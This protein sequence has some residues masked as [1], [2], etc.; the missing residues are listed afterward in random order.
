[1]C[2]G[3]CAKHMCMHVH[4][5]VNI[6]Y[7]VNHSSSYFMRLNVSLNLELTDWIFRLAKKNPIDICVFNPLQS[8]YHI[9]RA[10]KILENGSWRSSFFMGSRCWCI[11]TYKYAVNNNWKKSMNLKKRGE[12][13]IAWFGGRNEKEENVV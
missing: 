8:S 1:M 9:T 13:Y 10:T 5:K 7:L 4:A 12:R 11:Y 3:A 6:R 2:A